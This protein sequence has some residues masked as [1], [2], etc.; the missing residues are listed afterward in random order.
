MKCKFGRTVTGL[1][2]ISPNWKFLFLTQTFLIADRFD[3]YFWGAK[4]KVYLCC[5][6]SLAAQV[7]QEHFDNYSIL[8]LKALGKEFNMSKITLIFFTL[9]SIGQ[10][11]FC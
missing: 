4:A 9:S 11:F 6:I 1:K 3:L 8:L 2:S 10:D 5:S 7:T